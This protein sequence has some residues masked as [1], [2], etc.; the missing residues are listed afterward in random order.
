[1]SVT[2]PVEPA[3]PTAGV[4]WVNTEH[5]ISIVDHDGE[6]ID[7]FPIAHDAAGLRTLVRR[8]LTAGVGEVGIERPDGRP[9]GALFSGRPLR[10][11]AVAWTS[12]FASWR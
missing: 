8:L 2:D 4:D 1:M 7:R 5:A 9:R 3:R 11:D 12:E 6:Q 10:N